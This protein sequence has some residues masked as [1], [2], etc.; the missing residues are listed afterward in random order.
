MTKLAVSVAEATALTG[1]GKTKFYSEI[2]AGKI[3]VR[4]SGSR[5]VILMEDLEAYMR[6]LPIARTSEAA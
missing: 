2:K 4:K 6:A 5:T 3:Q 1:I